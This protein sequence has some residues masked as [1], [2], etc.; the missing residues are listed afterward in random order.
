[1]KIYIKKNI[2]DFYAHF[3]CNST[4]PICVSYKSNNKFEKKKKKYEWSLKWIDFYEL[5]TSGNFKRKG[6]M[7]NKKK[8]KKKINT[9]LIGY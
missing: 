7:K 6:C 8:N 4:R 5:V 9:Q 3:L 2:C 1:M